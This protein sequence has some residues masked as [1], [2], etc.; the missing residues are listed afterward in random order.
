MSSRPAGG[1]ARARPTRQTHALPP[2]TGAFCRPG[3]PPELA[4][5]R[6]LS[7]TGLHLLTMLVVVV[8]VTFFYYTLTAWVQVGGDGEC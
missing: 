4:A 7:A 1:P 8:G 5:Q 3:L 2:L 6:L